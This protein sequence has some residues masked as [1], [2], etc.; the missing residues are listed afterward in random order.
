MEEY[1]EILL[2]G[3]FTPVECTIILVA[4][5]LYRQYGFNLIKA[6]IVRETNSPDNKFKRYKY[7][8]CIDISPTVLKLCE[9]CLHIAAPLAAINILAWIVFSIAGDASGADNIVRVSNYFMSFAA[10]LLGL[11][12]CLTLKQKYIRA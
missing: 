3:V 9:A 11:A 2:G 12:I 8:G 5:W 4:S 1:F 10:L 7:M 6:W